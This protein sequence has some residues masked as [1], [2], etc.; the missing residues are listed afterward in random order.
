MQR[1]T[2]VI[3]VTANKMDWFHTYVK[4]NFCYIEQSLFCFFL[5]FLYPN[6]PKRK[7]PHIKMSNKHHKQISSR[8]LIKHTSSWYNSGTY[9]LTLHFRDSKLVLGNLNNLNLTIEK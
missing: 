4:S 1:I 5:L 3:T 8:A 6:T 7:T 2:T 9:F